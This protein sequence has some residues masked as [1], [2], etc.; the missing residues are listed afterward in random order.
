MERDNINRN[1]RSV[2]KILVVEDD[3]SCRWVLTLNLSFYGTCEVAVDGQ[4][5]VTAVRLAL[6]EES[7]YDLICL[8]IMMPRMNGQKA[9]KEIRRLEKEHGIPDGRGTK[10][11]MTTA[12]SDHKNIMAAFREQCDSYLVKPVKKADLVEKLKELELID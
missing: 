9:L 5:A 12:L 3:F 7:P 10:V 2:M 11:I 1:E 8:D 4:E 6:E